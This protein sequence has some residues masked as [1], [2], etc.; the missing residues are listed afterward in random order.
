MPAGPVI[1]PGGKITDLGDADADAIRIVSSRKIWLDHNTLYEGHDGLV[2]VTRGS[3]AITISN[4]WFRDHD[5]VML[6]GHDDEFVGDRDMQ[7]TLA[8]NRFG[9]NCVQRM[10]RI[11][12]GY[13]HVVNNFYD[14]WKDYAMGGSMNPTIKSQGN[15]YVAPHT[16]NKAVRTAIWHATC[17]Y[18]A[19]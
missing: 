18:C 16:E 1:G 2:D 14:G 5:K 15:L 19:I 10:P 4:N 6:L 7:V 17:K 8:F 11:R 12:H 3:T 9:P 13:A